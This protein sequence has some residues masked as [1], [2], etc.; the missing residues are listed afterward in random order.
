RP[1]RSDSINRGGE[2]HM[3]P[4]SPVTD[5]SARPTLGW[6]EMA[7][8]LDFPALLGHFA[9]QTNTRA[10]VYRCLGRGGPMGSPR[11]PREYE[12]EP[13]AA[14]GRRGN[15]GTGVLERVAQPLLLLGGDWDERPAG[16]PDF[17][18][19]QVDRRL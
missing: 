13:L 3:T 8:T 10:P 9:P 19:L 6:C 11:P 2:R 15:P 5:C 16:P 17:P 14:P 18:S 12:T 7:N 4:P 1:D